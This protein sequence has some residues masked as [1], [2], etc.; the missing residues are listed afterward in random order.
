MSS[1]A[2]ASI[3]FAGLIVATLLGAALRRL[4]PE[5]HLGG[6]AR[7]AMKLGTGLVA[8]L[9]AM[10]L[11]LLV[12]SAKG[13]FDTQ[14]TSLREAAADIILLDR[15]LAQ[16]GAET[17]EHRAFVRRT[18]ASWLDRVWP[19]EGA[20]QLSTE[21]AR[22]QPANIDLLDE[23]LRALAPTNDRQRELRARA[24]GL[25]EDLAH[26]RWL[27]FG[28]IGDRPI[29]LPFLVVL[30]AWLA[31][32]FLSFGLLAPCNPTVTL[33]LVVCALSVA[34]AVLLILELGRPFEGLLKLPGTPLRDALAAL[35]R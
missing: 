21:H 11:G 6:D 12:A 35:G 23:Q 10:V 29:A 2:V 7:D 32:L 19:E 27:L 28:R 30:A 8:T 1:L 25:C 22:S 9:A 34:T 15:S 17:L 5:H 20:I 18:L 14:N 31:I 26:T 24:L 33:S 4:L 3:L 16:Y 13:S